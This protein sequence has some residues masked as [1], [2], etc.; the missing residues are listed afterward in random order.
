MNMALPPTVYSLTPC[1]LTTPAR[2]A[3]AESLYKGLAALAELLEK[4]RPVALA[5]K[6]DRTTRIPAVAVVCRANAPGR[7]APTPPDEKL[8]LPD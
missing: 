6:L 3:L 5:I 7:Y 4:T 2:A 1:G 8:A